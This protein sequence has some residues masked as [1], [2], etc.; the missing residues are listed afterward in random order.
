[1]GY[2]IHMLHVIGPKYIKHLLILHPEQ[3]WHYY[4]INY[5]KFMAQDLVRV[6]TPR[7]ALFILKYLLSVNPMQ[8]SAMNK[9]G[10]WDL[11][12]HGKWEPIIYTGKRLN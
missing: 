3:K 9:A 10:P 4:I 5:S 12:G 1:M 2:T 6:L 11:M 8:S 7:L